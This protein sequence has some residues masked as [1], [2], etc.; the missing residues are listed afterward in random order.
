L[1]HPFVTNCRNRPTVTKYSSIRN[2]LTVAEFEV[3][4]A[5]VPVFVYVR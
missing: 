3:A 5:P 4:V 1:F 2:P